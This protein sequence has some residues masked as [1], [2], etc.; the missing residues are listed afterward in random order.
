MDYDTFKD[1][2]K[3]VIEIELTTFENKVIN[4]KEG[5]KEELDRISEFCQRLN[6]FIDNAET[7]GS[8]LRFR[9]W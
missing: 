5:T 4:E 3:K 7:S 8:V 6:L 2:I 9:G 1:K